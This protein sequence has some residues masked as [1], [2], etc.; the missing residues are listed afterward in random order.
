MDN[1]YFM[2]LA[3]EQAKLAQKI[4]EVL[5]KNQQPGKQAPGAAQDK[6]ADVK[7]GEVVDDKKPEEGEFKEK[8]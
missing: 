8:K 6:K 7:K 2:S 3:I 1:N 5:Y 4:G